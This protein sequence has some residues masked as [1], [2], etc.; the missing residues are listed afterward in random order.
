MGGIVV[1]GAGGLGREVIDM[2]EGMNS[3]ALWEIAGFAD[4]EPRG[5][6]NGY[7]VMSEDDL[8]NCKEPV[9]AVIAVGFPEAREKIYRRLSQN[10]NIRFPAIVHPTSRIGRGVDLPD[11]LLV[12][13]FCGVSPN[14][15][16]GRGVLLNGYCAVGH[17]VRIGDF[18][19]MMAYSLLAGNVKM[20][21]GVLAGAGSVVVQGLTIGDGAELCAGSVVVRDVKARSKVMGNP[22]RAIA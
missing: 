9:D 3:D 1:C 15:V 20:G 7:P 6:V 2:L 21:S 17:D 11:G 22:A 19:A 5:P 18:S 16:L 14:A 12:C 4:A 10:P 13:A 8:L